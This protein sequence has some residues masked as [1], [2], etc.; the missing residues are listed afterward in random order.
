M[1]GKDL[2][3]ENKIMMKRGHCA[4]PSSRHVPFSMKRDPTSSDGTL[5]SYSVLLMRS[6]IAHPLTT[7]TALEKYN[8]P[9]LS[10][11]MPYFCVSRDLQ[12]G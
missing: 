2:N 3:H 8:H 5:S 4:E 6:M 10:V 7:F 11:I 1:Q 12:D 9:G